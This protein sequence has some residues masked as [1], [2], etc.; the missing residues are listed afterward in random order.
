[1]H[2]V[3]TMA[4]MDYMHTTRLFGKLRSIFVSVVLVRHCQT[5]VL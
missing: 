1:M 5:D 2:S 4:A 3:G